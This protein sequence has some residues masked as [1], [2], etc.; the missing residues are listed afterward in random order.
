MSDFYLWSPYEQ[1]DGGPRTTWCSEVHPFVGS[2]PPPLRPGGPV[3]G[4]R[5][6]DG[7]HLPSRVLQGSGGRK[8]AGSYS[9]HSWCHRPQ[10]HLGGLRYH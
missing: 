7:T 8:P 9:Q 5:V 10:A 1:T 3:L 6:G 4:V 2:T